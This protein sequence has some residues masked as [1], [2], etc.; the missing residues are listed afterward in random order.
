MSAAEG[1][2]TPAMAIQQLKLAIDSSIHGSLDADI[3]PEESTGVYFE[4]DEVGDTYVNVTVED[5]VE[6][7]DPVSLQ[8]LIKEGWAQP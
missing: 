5:H 3:I 4:V 6:D 8:I 1:R 2:L 7:G